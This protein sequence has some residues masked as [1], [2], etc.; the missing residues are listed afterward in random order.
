MSKKQAKT[1]R[2]EVVQVEVITPEVLP[3]DKA[4]AAQIAEIAAGGEQ[5]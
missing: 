3:D 1:A 5:A 4:M 2:G